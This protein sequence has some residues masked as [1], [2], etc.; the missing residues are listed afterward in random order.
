MTCALRVLQ[1]PDQNDGM[2]NGHSSIGVLVLVTYS[3]LHVAAIQ[4][5]LSCSKIIL[6]IGLQLLK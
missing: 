6:R 2:N 3:K 1:R 5:L 4:M